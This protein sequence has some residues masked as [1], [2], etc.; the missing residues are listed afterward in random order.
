MKTLT[1]RLPETL[2]AEIE[3]E[4]RARRRSKSDVVRERLALVTRPRSRPVLPAI[5][6]VVGSVN[7]LPVDLSQRKKSYLRTTGYG[8]RAR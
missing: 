3:A 6:D 1:V 8:R 5:A 2:V 4:S 7:G